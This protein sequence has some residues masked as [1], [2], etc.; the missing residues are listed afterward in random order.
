M[1]HLFWSKFTY[2][3]FAYSNENVS[4]SRNGLKHF[5]QSL[6]GVLRGVDPPVVFFQNKKETFTAT[7]L[8]P[9][10][11]GERVHEETTFSFITPK[12]QG[13]LHRSERT[14]DAR[15]SFNKGIYPLATAHCNP[16]ARAT[17]KNILTKFNNLN[18]LFFKPPPPDQ[19]YEDQDGYYCILA[20]FRCC[21]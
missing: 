20:V 19:P 14:F 7:A 9:P 18:S 2:N 11:W 15:P 4:K 6:A 21:W 13:G 8:V 10:T 12:A 1:T 16:V 5:P 17:W 3:K